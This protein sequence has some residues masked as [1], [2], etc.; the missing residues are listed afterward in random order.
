MDIRRLL[1]YSDN[2]KSLLLET[3]AAHSGVFDAPFPTLAAYD[4]IGKLVAHMVGAEQ[5]WTVQRLYDEP[6]PSRY[7]DAPTATLEGVFADWE[8]IRA[9]TRAFVAAADDAALAR[10]IPVTLP[11]WDAACELTT[12]EIL[13]HL[14]NHQTFHTAQISMA[15][16]QRQIDPPNFDFVLLR[17]A[18]G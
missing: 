7:E 16:Q 18:D 14:V 8:A 17:P 12:E 2:A 6:R 1:A 4:T 11:Q 13:F 9:R 10:T 15:L 5:R 3:L